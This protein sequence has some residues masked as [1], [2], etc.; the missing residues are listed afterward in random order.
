MYCSFCGSRN[1]TI[2]NCSKTHSGSVN[3]MHMGCSFCGGK[4]HN[5]QACP[6]THSGSAARAWHPETVSDNFIED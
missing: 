2:R 4:N 3:R 6:K 1:H 5:V